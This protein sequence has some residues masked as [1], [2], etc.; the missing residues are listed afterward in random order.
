MNLL[1]VGGDRRMLLLRT[2]LEKRGHRVQTLGIVEADEG[3]CDPSKADA[4]V[5][6]YPFSVKNGRV[7]TLTGVDIQ[8]EKV[9]ASAWTGVPVI[10]GRGLEEWRFAKRYEQSQIFL[11]QNADLSAEA[12][13]FEVMLRADRSLMDLCILITGY[14]LFGRSVALKLKALGAAVR[15]AVRRKE[16]LHQAEADGMETCSLEGM[17]GRLADV[18][19]VLNTVPAPI[20]KESELRKLS[21]GT[22]LMELASAPYGFDR[23]LAAALG[24]NAVLLPGLPARYAP[25]SA[26]LALAA[27]VEDLLKE[28]AE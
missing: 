15:I 19:F 6:A 4:L 21:G 24:L 3:L 7:P 12:A 2:L 20:W 5:F 13:V 17:G 26:A 10:V 23:D 27:A 11:K 25:C 1:L 8:P 16:V 18:D 22:W 14:G 9:L 28:D